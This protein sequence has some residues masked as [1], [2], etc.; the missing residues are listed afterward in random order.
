MKIRSHNQ[1]EE[2]RHHHQEISGNEI[3]LSRPAA[4]AGELSCM[5]AYQII[6]YYGANVSKTW[7]NQLCSALVVA[8][9]ELAG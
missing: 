4:A 9:G 5:H 7:W 6:S 8:E 3:N 2:T 1:E